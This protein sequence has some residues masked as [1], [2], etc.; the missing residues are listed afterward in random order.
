MHLR[1]GLVASLVI[2]MLAALLAGP[3]ASAGGLDPAPLFRV[4]ALPSDARAV[5]E[6]TPGIQVG[7]APDAAPR[8]YLVFDAH[9]P[10]CARTYMQLREAHPDVPVRWVPVAYFAA[11]S[12]AQ[13]AAILAAADPAKA[14]DDNFR[15]YDP[16]AKRGGYVRP[17]TAPAVLSPAHQ[18]L[19]DAWRRWGGYTPMLLLRG[20]DGRQWFKATEIRGRRGMEQVLETPLE[21]SAGQALGTYKE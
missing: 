8:A 7:G 9:C 5:L 10:A 19:R 13:A 21:G 12:G 3:I 18:Q 17:G 1:L 20:A 14:L 11:D 4:K 6:R 2:G 16:A 15:A